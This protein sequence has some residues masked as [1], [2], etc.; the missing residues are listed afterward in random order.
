M[1]VFIRWVVKL[2]ADDFSPIEITSSESRLRDW[3]SLVQAHGLN[4]C[5]TEHD[6]PAP[7]EEEKSDEEIE[8]ETTSRHMDQCAA[9][10]EDRKG[11]VEI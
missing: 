9:L 7:G 4:Q 11:K 1:R 2:G 6:I 8:R 5:I 10:I 3:P